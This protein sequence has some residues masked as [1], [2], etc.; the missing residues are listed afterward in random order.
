MIAATYSIN[1]ARLGSIDFA[2]PYLLTHQSMLVDAKKS[3]IT[4]FR[5][6]E[7]KVLCSVT[8]STTAAN[9]EKELSNVFV[10]EYD[11]YSSCAEAVRQGNAD[12]MT[13]DAT[14]LNGYIFQSPGNF[15]LV[16]L[17]PEVKSLGGEYYGIGLPKG[18]TDG[19][20]AINSALMEMIDDGSFD[21]FVDENLGK[22]AAVQAAEPGDFSFLDN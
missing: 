16:E 17:A 10:Q 14:I 2:G 1:E 7:G 20:N 11:T 21:K 12:A 22:T 19:V 4:D 9:I 5:D 3:D 15:R 18:D 13:T 6:L 8:N